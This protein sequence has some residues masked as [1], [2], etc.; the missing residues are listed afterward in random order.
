MRVVS[1]VS[2]TSLQPVFQMLSFASR[3]STFAPPQP[4]RTSTSTDPVEVVEGSPE[5]VQLL[6]ADAFGVSRQDLVLDLVDGAGD[7][8][9]ELLPA[10]TDVLRAET[11][12]QRKFEEKWS[13][14][15]LRRV[16]SVLTE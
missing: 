8:G 15:R 14:G 11:P 6:L 5:L 7:G 10:H 3:L 4:D 12:R 13:G 9:E 1:M 2:S 16:V